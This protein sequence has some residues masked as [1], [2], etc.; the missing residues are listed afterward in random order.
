MGFFQFLE[1]SND[2]RKGKRGLKKTLPITLDQKTWIIPNTRDLLLQA[3]PFFIYFAKKN[4][5]LNQTTV[6]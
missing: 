5:F 4:P 1:L 2:K 6:M 3:S